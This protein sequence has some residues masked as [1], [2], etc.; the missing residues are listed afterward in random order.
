MS[1]TLRLSFAARQILFSDGKWSY[2]DSGVTGHG[3]GDSFPMC[4]SVD[5]TVRNTTM[6]FDML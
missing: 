5:I 6:S 3:H 4:R 2:G 1:Y